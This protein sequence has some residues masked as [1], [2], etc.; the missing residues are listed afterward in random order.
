[1]TDA[2]PI[3]RLLRNG[4]AAPSVS[5]VMLGRYNAMLHHFVPSGL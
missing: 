5:R 3:I 1:M 2:F 4:A